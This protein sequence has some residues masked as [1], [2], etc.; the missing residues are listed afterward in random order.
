MTLD[1][2]GDVRYIAIKLRQLNRAL[3]A[4]TNGKLP[5]KRGKM[6]EARRADYILTMKSRTE[7]PGKIEIFRKSQWTGLL[8]DEAMYRLRI[9]NVWYGGGH[10]D[11]TFLGKQDVMIIIRQNLAK[12]GVA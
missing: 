3:H 9:N 12:G 10:K 11:M 5:L 4:Q 1:H 8:A 7:A 6:S 2:R